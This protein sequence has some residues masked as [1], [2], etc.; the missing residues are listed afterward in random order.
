MES[1]HGGYL[2]SNVY[3]KMAQHAFRPRWVHSTYGIDIDY[4][5]HFS[6]HKEKLQKMFANINEYVAEGARDVEYGKKLG[7]KGRNWLFPAAGGG[8]DLNQFSQRRTTAPSKR[9][10]ILIK[11]YQDSVRRGMVA[12][13]ALVKCK[14]ILSDYEVFVYSCPD[15]VREYVTYINSKENMHISIHESGEY[16]SWLDFLSKARVSVTNNLSDGNPIFE[17]MLMG[18]FHLQSESSCAGEWIDHGKTGYLIPPEDP[19]SIAKYLREALTND[20]L[21]D[22]AAGINYERVASELEYSKEKSRILDLY[23]Q[24]LLASQGPCSRP[25]T[26]SVRSGFTTV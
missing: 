3:G 1:Q 20:D 22:R 21:V 11:G 12:I 17:S 15:I 26:T 25:E 5:I 7:F 14:D 8:Y 6:D 4:F 10:K 18:V 2:V 16:E 13:R 19:E 24:T 9:K 23:E